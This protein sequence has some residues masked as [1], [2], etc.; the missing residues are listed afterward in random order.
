ETVLS[1]CDISGANTGIICLR[2]SPTIE[3][4]QIHDNGGARIQEMIPCWEA[5]NAGIY[6]GVN[7][8][9]IISNNTIYENRYGIQCNEISR[10][11]IFDNRI[12]NNTYG[13]ASVEDDVIVENNSVEDNQYG[14]YCYGAN[15][16]IIWN[17]IVGNYWGV[18]C[19]QY[20]SPYIAG[21]VIENNT[22][23]GIW[24]SY[25]STPSIVGNSVVGNN[26]YG[27]YC[28]WYSSPMIEGNVIENN[29][30]Y[31]VYCCDHST[32]SIVGNHIANHTF[33]LRC[34]DYSSPLIENNTVRNSSEWGVCLDYYASPLIIGN[35]FTNNLNGI[36]CGDYSYPT[37]KNNNITLCTRGI[38]SSCLASPVIEGCNIYSNVFG[39]DSINDPIYLFSSNIYDND[40]GIRLQ[41]TDMV[42]FNTT[43]SNSA[44]YD[45]YIYKGDAVAT[46]STFD[47]EKVFV[48]SGQLIVNWYLDISVLH[49]GL[50][51][52][53][54]AVTVTDA[55]GNEI[56]GTTDIQGDTGQ[57]VV[58]E[59]KQ[60][61]IGFTYHTPHIISVSCPGYLDA[62]TILTVDESI[63]ITMDMQEAPS[64]LPAP[65]QKFSPVPLSK[66]RPAPSTKFS[67]VPAL[68]VYPVSLEEDARVK[69]PS[70]PTQL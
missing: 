43:I 50:P 36:G 57:V 40:Y 70:Q 8:Q 48:A 14:I 5:E 6:C 38:Y 31:G 29:T 33:G 54:A 2:S 35:L 27:I 49:N 61:S 12:H 44:L 19:H 10:P 37:I 11:V 67:P 47:K 66:F 17:S 65:P 53:G 22:G 55:L 21:N 52:E 32:P 46:N 1:Y 25:Y 23:Y 18:C 64:S 26:H 45:I 59:Y 56:T 9:P 24:C 7:S 69:D 3:H 68:T 15:S 34:R 42:M 16:T 41:Y 60:T 28:Y 39:I 20:S 62:S 4:C 63:S 51:L 13:I 30:E 58:T